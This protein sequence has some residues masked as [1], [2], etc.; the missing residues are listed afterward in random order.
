MSLN[1]YDR[2]WQVAKVYGYERTESFLAFLKALATDKQ[3]KALNLQTHQKRYSPKQKRLIIEVL[4]HPL[5]E[6]SLKS[7]PNSDE[8]EN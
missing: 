7:N 1:K 8:S 6:A 3:W 5:D 4:G 2:A